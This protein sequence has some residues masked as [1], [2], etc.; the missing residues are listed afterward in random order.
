MTVL[1]P[2]APAARPPAAGPAGFVRSDQTRLVDGQGQ[3]LLMRGVN[4]GN[5]LLPEGYMWLFGPQAASPRQIEGLVE[6]LTGPDWAAEF[7]VRY[8]DVFIA[9]ADIARIAACGFDHV[10]LPLNAR[11]LQDRHGRPIEAGHALVDRL[12]EWCRRW[13]LRVLLDLHGAPG[14]QTGTNIDDSPNGL[15]ELFLDPAQQDLTARLWHDLAARHAD[16]P[17]VLGYDLLNEPLP[18]QWQDRHDDLRACYRRLTATIRAVDQ[19]HLL[20]YEGSHWATNWTVFDEV[21][22]D[23]SALQFHKYWSPPDRES[24]AVFLRARQ[25]LGLPIF[26]GESGENTVEWLYT[27]FR[28][29]ESEG[30]GW[31][32]W[33]WKKLQTRTSPV[34]VLAPHDW[35]RVIDSV[36]GPARLDRT[37]ARAC[38]EQLLDRVQL[39]R[40]EWREDVVRALLGDR[41]SRIPAW[42][43]GWRGAGSSHQVAERCDDP[44]FRLGD[45]APIRFARSD[46]PPDNPFGQTDGRDYSAAETLT[47]DLQAGDWLEF[48][49]GPSARTEAVICLDLNGDAAPVTVTGVDRGL[50]VTAD[51][52]TRLV[53]I[54]WK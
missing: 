1:G 46:D 51:Q 42:G 39:E 43:F 29:Y 34:S 9:E 54:E 19:N 47:V 3:E 15:P 44:V 22:D 37:E 36:D 16:E 33:P 6:R 17:T 52:S 31:T 23:N 4:L 41:P 28:L 13:G 5:W 12:I 25:R 27:A 14:G 35:R 8:R 21:W 24:L 10:R 38:F 7:W 53:R 20:M 26:M 32:F 48:E 49:V 2:S 50:R 18:N 11:V 40:A 45:R 30:I